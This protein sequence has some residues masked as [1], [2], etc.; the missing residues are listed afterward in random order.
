MNRFHVRLVSIQLVLLASALFIMPV[1]AVAEVAISEAAKFLPDKIESFHANA[2]AGMVIDGIFKH[3]VAD[4]SGT[5]SAAA[6]DYSNDAGAAFWVEV[7]RTDNDST[8]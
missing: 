6:R 2:P 1:R 7:V 8:A 3:P 4:E 5:I